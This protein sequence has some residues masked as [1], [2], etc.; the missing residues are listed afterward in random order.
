MV[1]QGLEKQV[2]FFA[3]S[4]ILYGQS[5]PHSPDSPLAIRNDL[6]DIPPFAWNITFSFPRWEMPMNTWT[7]H[8]FF[9]KS[10]VNF[11]R[12]LVIHILYSCGL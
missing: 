4:S 9:S 12:Q 2:L 5:S 10:F 3:S 11:S 6:V 8:R 1:S 7:E